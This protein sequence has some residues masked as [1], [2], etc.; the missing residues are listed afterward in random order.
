MESWKLE[1]FS[2]VMEI[3][4]PELKLT[5][6]KKE[7]QVQL[8]C[9]HIRFFDCANDTTSLKQ[10]RIQFF[11]NLGNLK[12]NHVTGN[13]QKVSRLGDGVRLR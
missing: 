4:V 12:K 2:S 1:A 8:S 6:R 11:T 5:R 9:C 7:E 13:F 3:L 10:S